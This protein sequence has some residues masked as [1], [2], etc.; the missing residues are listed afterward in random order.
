VQVDSFSHCVLSLYMKCMPTPSH[1]IELADYADDRAIKAMIHQLQSLVGY[2]HT[3]LSTLSTGYM[4][5]GLSSVSQRALWFSLFSLQGVSESSIRF[6]SLGSQCTES[7]PL[8]IWGM[9]LDAQLTDLVH[10]NQF[11]RRQHRGWEF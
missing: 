3:F 11:G 7:I 2:L 4:I 6:R 1:Y 9:I 8:I 5:A 10:I